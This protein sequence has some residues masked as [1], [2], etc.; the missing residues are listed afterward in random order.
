MSDEIVEVSGGSAQLS[1][2]GERRYTRKF[3]L[4]FDSP[5]YDAFAVCSSQ[6]LPAAYSPYPGD[7]FAVLVSFN[8]QQDSDPG[9]ANIWTV[10]ANYSESRAVGDLLEQSQSSGNSPGAQID[11][12]QTITINWS[13]REVP[14]YREQDLNGNAILTSAGETPQIQQP[15]F[16]LLRVATIKYFN[17]YK[18]SDLMRYVNH[19]NSVSFTC[20]GETAEPECA[21]IASINCSEWVVRRGVSGRD[22][23]VTLE[24]GDPIEDVSLQ[25]IGKIA[26]N[27]DT[28]DGSRT[29][30]YFRGNF[31][32]AGY[33]EYDV[34]LGGLRRIRM[35][36]KSYASSPQPLALG[37]SLPRPVPAGTFVYRTFKRF[38][39]VDFS[40]IMRLPQ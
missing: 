16:D 1:V 35:D 14:V 15:H 26:P 19:I 27:A 17:R 23:V 34:T 30:P 31:L 32:D 18:P 2:G 40:T 21:R 11:P 22:I 10:T 9:R 38:P 3:R 13:S 12:E 20:D 5:I 24:I 36:D 39:S 25:D 28:L 6:L 8:A 4:H 37:V 33:M 7:A 29:L